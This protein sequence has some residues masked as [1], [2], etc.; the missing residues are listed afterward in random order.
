M[1]EASRPYVV[2]DRRWW[3]EDE[4]ASA[5]EPSEERK[6][7]YVEELEARNAEL[8]QSV[9]D[10]RQRYRAAVDE[11]ER[12]R[13]RIERDARAQA[14]RDR[15][16]VLLRML[17]VLDDLDRAIDAGRSARD[18]GAVVEGIELV[19]RSFL[20]ALGQHGIERIEAADAA[21]DPQLHD[22]VSTVPVTDPERSGTVVGVVR[23]GYR[24]GDHILRPA[25]VAV[26]NCTD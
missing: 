19:R 22:A 10:L 23:P 16:A 6:P 4:A 15:N 5:D 18:P 20:A 24:A 1:S 14:E 12:A 25:Q 17:E 9:A 26:G 21:F 8:E 13:H 3:S 2:R 11:L 7:R